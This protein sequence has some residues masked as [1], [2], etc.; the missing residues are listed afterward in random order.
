MTTGLLLAQSNWSFGAAI[1]AGFSGTS[2]DHR[3]FYPNP[4][5]GDYESINSNK[6][7]PS[8]GAG[9]WVERRLGEHWGLMTGIDYL[10]SRTF[11]RFESISYTL[12]GAMNYYSRE[13]NSRQQQQL[14]IPLEVHF[15]FGKKS[16]N[17]RPFISAGM[18]AQYLLKEKSILENFY[19]TSG[20]PNTEYLRTQELDFDSEYL[21][22]PRAQF[23]M[24]LG[25][26][27]ASERM[28]L[29]LRRSQSTGGKASYLGCNCAYCDGIFYYDCYYPTYNDDRQFQLAQTSLRF[30]YRLF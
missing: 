21:D 30:E 2:E 29:T 15:Y 8:M 17:W 3:D 20:Q 23:G 26:G 9:L 25:L 12:E 13:D 24:N 6:L 7:Q 5:F 4:D 10:A 19:G 22:Y 18:Q 11:S 28:S 27:I 14:Q 16:N 1:H